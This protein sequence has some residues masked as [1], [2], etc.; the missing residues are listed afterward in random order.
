MNMVHEKNTVYNSMYNLPVYICKQKNVKD[1]RIRKTKAVYHQNADNLKMRLTIKRDICNKQYIY[2][3]AKTK[4][5][6][7][8]AQIHLADASIQHNL[9]MSWMLT[10]SLTTIHDSNGC[11]GHVVPIAKIMY[12]KSTI[13]WAKQH[14]NDENI[15]K[16]I[17]ENDKTKNDPDM[18]RVAEQ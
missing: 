17:L 10:S 15:I 3:S 5:G 14:Y 6:L 7:Y 9:F 13:N 4:R 2:D 12:K 1:I 16:L 11:S 8:V 18:I